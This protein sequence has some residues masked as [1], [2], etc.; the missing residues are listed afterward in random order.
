MDSK[1]FLLTFP[2]SLTPQDFFYGGDWEVSRLELSEILSFAARLIHI[3]Y[4][5]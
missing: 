2:C 3:R 5:A 4:R 1:P